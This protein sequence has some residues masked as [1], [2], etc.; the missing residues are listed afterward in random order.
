MGRRG[1]VKELGED[2]VQCGEVVVVAV[3]QKVPLS[4]VMD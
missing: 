4:C 2:T 1:R 3:E